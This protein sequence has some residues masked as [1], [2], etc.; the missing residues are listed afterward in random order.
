MTTYLEKLIETPV[1]SRIRKNHGLEH[2]AIHV[3]SRKFPGVRLVGHSD[4]Q[5]FWLVGDL[6]K[7]QVRDGVLTAM[8]RLNGGERKLAVHPNCGTNYVTSGAFAGLAAVAALMGARRPMEKLSRL[9]FVIAVATIAL[10]VSQPFGFLVQ[11]KVTTTG[12]LGEMEI[13]EI[14]PAQRGQFKAHRVVTRG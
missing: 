10:I 8:A 5:G 4:P 7:D 14:I 12:D 1:L 11:E 6:T 9:P 3:L 13:V 2:A